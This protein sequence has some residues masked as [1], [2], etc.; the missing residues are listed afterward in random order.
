MIKTCKIWFQVLLLRRSIPNQ[1]KPNS[2]QFSSFK[3]KSTSS[4]ILFTTQNM[5]LILS[6]FK[7]LCHVCV[8]GSRILGL[9]RIFLPYRR[10]NGFS[11]QIL[12]WHQTNAFHVSTDILSEGAFCLDLVLSH[13][14]CLFLNFNRFIP[15]FRGNYNF[16]NFLN[17]EDFK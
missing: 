15:Y 14:K 10:T 6:T 1:I 8:S 4:N 2:H 16:S 3:L 12:P 5:L 7:Q 13:F 11:L 9:G 17:V